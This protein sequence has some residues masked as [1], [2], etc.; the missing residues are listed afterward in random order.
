VFV[1]D[2]GEEEFIISKTNVIP[3]KSFVIDTNSEMEISF[4]EVLITSTEYQIV[5]FDGSRCK[6]YSSADTS[7]TD[8][9]G[10][11]DCVRDALHS[12]NSTNLNCS[13]A[14]FIDDFKNVKPLCNTSDSAVESFTT[15]KNFNTALSQNPERFGCTKPCHTSSFKA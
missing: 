6:E 9:E 15:M 5:E 12:Y 13:V 10:F 7:E 4:A 8:F 1:H 3:V 11:K 14:G 2:S